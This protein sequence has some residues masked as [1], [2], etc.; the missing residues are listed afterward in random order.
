MR[1]IG[2][3]LIVAAFA[4]AALCAQAFAEKRVALVIGN[5]AYETVAKLPNPARDA[6]AMADLFKSAG[7]ET[8]S[9]VKDV[10]NLEFKRA[11]RRFEEISRD[12]D[13]AVVFYAGHGIEI[14]GVNYM[15]PV[16]AR[17]ASDLDAVDEAITLDRLMETV[18]SSRKLGLV[19]LDACRDNPFVASMKRQRH[20]SR[21]ITAGLGKVEPTVAG[22]LVAYAARAGSTAEDGVG[23]HSPFT[24]A[25]LNHLTEPGLDVRLAFGRVRDDVMKTTNKRQEPFVYGSLGGATVAIVGQQ[26][27]IAAQKTTPS[28]TQ[29]G[30][31]TAEA[32]RDYEYFERVGT[33]EAWD[34]FL[35]L[36]STGPYADLARMQ[37]GRLA[38][39]EV[40]KQRQSSEPADKPA[41]V[42]ASATPSAKPEAAAPAT[43]AGPAPGEVTRM[44][45]TELKRVGCYSGAVN[46]E[47]N[48]ASRRALEQFNK[49][50]STKLDGKVASLSSVEAVREKQARVCPLTCA[51]GFKAEGEQCVAITCPSGQVVGSS[52]SC[53]TPKAKTA[54]RSEP[55]RD[56]AKPKRQ[57]APRSQAPRSNA[58]GSGQAVACDR[59]SC[60]PVPRGCRV[61]TSEFRGETQQTVIC[62]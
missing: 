60:K 52:G 30:D 54:T 61:Q 9:L 53:E 24:R 50:A 32:R 29:A 4:L 13:V 46:G 14:G 37:R 3:R 58:G 47:W 38:A 27:A 42:I 48:S 33:K 40:T 25:L 31:S 5:S 49:S 43:A 6:D 7:F 19:I 45:Q 26:Q 44:L 11:I 18:D 55:K 36:H 39:A 28:N 2:Y 62:N 59:F 21:A 23:E 8:V 57:A 17:L 22:T 56:A 41:T 16:D 10:G 12:A 1:S 35:R 51:K 34:A 15:I 20:A